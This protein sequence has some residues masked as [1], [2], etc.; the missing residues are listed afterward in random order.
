[1]PLGNI[2]MN[3][4]EKKNVATK[5]SEL[6]SGE[7]EER[8]RLILENAKDF[9]IFSLELD[10]AVASWNPGAER[11]FGYPE[12]EILGQNGQILFTPEDRER[13]EAEKELA[14]ALHTGFSRDERWH[15]RK[16]GSRFFASG[17]VR[18]MQD[19]VGKQIGFIKICRDITDRITMEERLRREKEY[20]DTIVNSL[21][22]IFYLF[23]ETGKSLR[24]NE[25]AERVTGYSTEEISRRSPLDFFEGPD[26]EQVA[27]GI[28]RA[29]QEGHS[30]TEA[31]LVTKDGRR[32]PHLFSGHRITLAGIPCVMGMGIDIT[33]RREAERGAREAQER[34]RSYAA[35]LESRV[36]E[37]TANLKQSVQSLEGVLYHVAHDLRAPLRA[38]ASF[39]S[40]LLDDYAPKLD[41]RGQDYAR[42]I[43]SAASHMD[44]L[45]QDLLAFGRLA[46]TEV[47]LE[48]V[49][50]EN[51]I[52]A[53]L[54]RFASEI[55]SLKAD[56]EVKRPL[57][58]IKANHAVLNEVITNLL[59]NALKFIPSD[60]NPRIRIWAE[61]RDG[62]VRLCIADD[63]IGIKPEYHERIFRMFERLHG[64]NV[65][66]GT[67]IGLAIVSK[68]IERM[69]G[70][71]GVESDDGK[72]AQFWFELPAVAT[73]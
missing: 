32:I 73:E 9:A 1:M 2:F 54:E 25:N 23:D 49:N 36:I 21:P 4:G 65:Y 38:M 14:T 18:V 12:A 61:R 60:R 52:N 47:P 66:P 16:D 20:S 31:V 27:Q 37:R 6:A 72:G 8:W 63:G 45:V 53:A 44:R 3:A 28:C 48:K 15:L 59:S 39:T 71:V 62:Q 67:G 56:I 13:K 24:W 26:R 41:E 34:L 42:R 22:G 7:P 35:E 5:N 64:M 50:L 68:G 58:P 51:E 33:E 70:R 30:T 29:L 17:I 40:I 19:R 57:P 46:H 11:I 43:R 69:G 10:G 55:K